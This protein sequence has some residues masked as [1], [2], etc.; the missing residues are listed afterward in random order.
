MLKQNVQLATQQRQHWKHAA[1][2]FAPLRTPPPSHLH[3][4]CSMVTCVSPV[5][6][7]YKYSSHTE[8]NIRVAA[9]KMMK[10]YTDFTQGARPLSFQR[11]DKVYNRKPLHV[12][13]G[14]KRYTEP[15]SIRG[16]I[17]DSPYIL[18]DGKTW[19]ASH[20]TSFPVSAAAADRDIIEPAMDSPPRTRRLIQRPATTRDI[21]L[22]VPFTA[23]LF[24]EKGKCCV[25]ASVTMK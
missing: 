25:Q 10:T 21:I 22:S 13:K 12:R 19:N 4:T 14:H 16:K 3:V 7:A 8:M 24:P 15:R 17:G 1:I 23:R 2:D 5:F 20:L 18:S 6:W 11:W 9:S